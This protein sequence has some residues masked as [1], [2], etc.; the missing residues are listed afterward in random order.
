MT[1]LVLMSF[2]ATYHKAMAQNVGQWINFFL[3]GYR[4]PI[5]IIH[6]HD[7][8][9]VTNFFIQGEITSPFDRNKL[10]FNDE[11]E[12]MKL[13]PFQPLLQNS[14]SDSPSIVFA[15][16]NPTSIP[17]LISCTLCSRF[18]FNTNC[19]YVGLEKSCAS[20]SEDTC[21]EVVE[22]VLL[23]QKIVKWSKD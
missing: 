15:V 18:H 20:D 23:G 3:P 1:Y 16:F 8:V 6:G 10:T 11:D 9:H 12:T 19:D 21:F 13:H 5:R 2:F 22:L 7:C 4:G 17:I 14:V